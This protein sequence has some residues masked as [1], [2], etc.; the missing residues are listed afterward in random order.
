[1]AAKFGLIDYG[2]ALEKVLLAQREVS[3]VLQHSGEV[4][5][6]REFFVQSVL[7]R[8]LPPNVVIG[9]GEIVDRL[10]GRSNQQDLLL[11]RNNFPVI[12][13]LA[14]THV[15]LAEGVLATIEVK[16][17]LNGDEVENATRNIKSVT[18]LD[19][20]SAGLGEAEEVMGGPSGVDALSPEAMARRLSRGFDPMPEEDPLL[21]PAVERIWTFLFAFDSVKVETLT[22]HA[23]ER[24]WFRGAGPDGLCV[25]GRAFGASSDAPFVLPRR[26]ETDTFVIEETSEPLGWWL[27]FL[28]WTLGRAYRRPVL[29]PYFGR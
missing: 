3:T 29:R 6:A 22:E 25:L 2:S 11:Y 16:T 24:G 5:R 18:A 17:I 1:M 13:S 15:Y 12:D 20:S 27:G 10:G 7:Q 9:S 8:V 4:G 26:S 23:E 21:V 14:G 19:V 28:L